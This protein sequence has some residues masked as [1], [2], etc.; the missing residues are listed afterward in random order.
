M[1]ATTVRGT[2]A[3]VTDGT[4]PCGLLSRDSVFSKRVT[5]TMNTLSEMS[6]SP[7]ERCVVCRANERFEADLQNFSPSYLKYVQKGT[8][9]K[10]RF[11]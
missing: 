9:P 10:A 8:K 4:R 6:T 3:D 7:R 11:S 5:L 2:E 1:S